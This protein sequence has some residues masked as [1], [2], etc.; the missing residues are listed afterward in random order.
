M[1]WTS[2]TQA[3]GRRGVVVPLPPAGACSA[4]VHDRYVDAMVSALLER[5]ELQRVEPL[6]VVLDCEAEISA[7]VAQDLDHVLHRSGGWLRLVVL[8]RVDPALPLHRYRLAGTV[9]EVRMGD[10][11]FTLDEAR[12]LMTNAGTDL[13]ETA[14]EAIV[15]RT[16]GW[17]AGLRFAA[18]SLAQR[19]DQEHAALEFSGAIGDVAEYLIAEV[20]DVQ[21]PGGRQFLLETSIVDALRPGLSEAVAGPQAQR[22][23]AV[24]IRG[25]AFLDELADSPG[26]YCYHPLFRDLLRAELAYESPARVPELHRAA[27]AWMAGQGRVEES[28]RHCAAGGDWEGATRYLIDDLAIG[29]LVLPGTDGLPSVLA[30]MPDTEGAAASLVRAAM[31]MA[32]FDVESCAENLLRAEGQLDGVRNPHWS[33]AEFALALVRLIHAA[34]VADVEGGL[35]AAAAAQRLLHQQV[36][37][38]LGE[39]PELAALIHACEGDL[40]LAS[41]RFNEAAE[42][43]AAGARA[44]DQPGCEHVLIN[45]LGQLALVAAIGGRLRK[46]GDLASRAIVV[47]QQSGIPAAAC[48]RAAEVAWAWV[49]TELYDLSAARRHAQR[50]AQAQSVGNDMAPRVMLALVEARVRRARGDVDGALDGIVAARSETPLPPRWLQDLL[51]IEEAE[52]NIANGQPD[53]AAR[54]VEVLYEPGSPEGA[55]V[56]ARARMATGETFESP[57]TTLRSAAASLPTRVGGWLLE[58]TRQLDGGEQLRAGQA[59]ARSLRLAAPERLRR[60]FREASPQVHRL[61]RGDRHLADEHSWLGAATLDDGLPHLPLRRNSEPHDIHQRAP[62]PILEPL[63]EREREVL[64]HLAALLT[65]DEIAGAMFLSVN[66]IRTHVRNI[67]RK[68][69]SSRR[70][71]AVRRA[72]ELGIIPDWTTVEP[73]TAG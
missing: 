40:W 41:G 54:I 28:V 61:L 6:V 49:N 30:R 35:G 70:N 57:A 25:N 47:Q 5:A 60:P 68:L 55:L 62:V 9:V 21:P 33:A 26:C 27:A 20:L 8:T 64:G 73:P 24:L 17:V 29:R 51:R 66:T 7:E 18:R 22:A 43:F 42:A 36:Q 72:R 53:L 71:E 14:L 16:R 58:A 19:E 50:A 56:L 11:A 65:T 48:P 59:L 15:A 37:G 4:E 39:H 63:T 10:L 45:C 2:F 46:A 23:L 52:L 67:L 31:A 34:A 1:F 38:R 69:A 13:S 32:V 3:L 12:E 44:G